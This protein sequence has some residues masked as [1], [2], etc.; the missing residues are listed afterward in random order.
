M[1]ATT[2]Y[3]QAVQGFQQ[4][5]LAPRTNRAVPVASPSILPATNTAL[6][7]ILSSDNSNDEN[8]PRPATATSPLEE[9]FSLRDWTLKAEQQSQQEE[10]ETVDHNRNSNRRIHKGNNNNNNNNSGE[11]KWYEQA[12]YQ[13][14]RQQRRRWLEKTTDSLIQSEPGTLVKGKWHELT[15]MLYAWSSFTKTDA[16]APLRMEAILKRLHQERRAGNREAKADIEMYNRLLDAWACAALF[17]TQPSA[18]VASQRAREILVLLQETYE[19]QQFA[20]EQDDSSII[21]EPSLMPNEESFNLVL[22]VVCR[23]EG[24]TIA[25]RLLAFM[26]YLH[27]SGKNPLAKPKRTDYVSVLTAYT[28]PKFRV[29]NAG[30]LVEGFLRH[31]NI[32]GG[33]APDTFCYNLAIKAWSQSKKGR[34]AAEH[35]DRILEEMQAPKDIV[36]YA[37]VIS[38]WSTSGMRAHAV[39][40]AEEV[41]RQIENEPHLEPNTI[42]L[43]AVMSTWVKSRSPG[44]SNRTGELLKH[45]EESSLPSIQPDLIT[46]NTHLHALSLQAKKPGMAQRADALLQKMENR[47]ARGEVDFAPNLFSYNLVIEAWSKAP[48]AAMKA[49]HVLR[50]LAKAKGVEP[51]TFS[52]NQVLAA[53]SRSSMT[54]Q[55]KMAE[56]LLDYMVKAHREGVH[57][58]AKPDHKGYTHVIQAHARSGV[59]GAA[60]KAERL[61]QHMKDRYF[62]HKEG[63]IKP[64]RHVYN[65]VIHC[66]A[67]SGEGTLGARKAEALLKEMQTLREQ[68]NDESMA[69][70]LVTFNCVLNAWALSGTR[71]CGHKA[72]S[73][74]NQMWEL[75]NAGDNNLVKPN[76]KSYNTV[77]NAISKSKN[78]AKAQRALRILRRMD[79]LYQAGVN[80]EARPNEVTYTAVLNSCAFPAVLDEKT[81]RKALDTAIFTLE[82]LKASRYGHP[83]QITYGTFFKACAN[84]LPDDDNLRRAI[85]QEAFLQC[86]KDGQVGDRVLASFRDASPA[87]LYDELVVSAVQSSP[88]RQSSR[89][90]SVRDLP[91]EWSRNSLRPRSAPNKRR[92]VPQRNRYRP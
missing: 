51:D 85:I 22:H 65:A 57:P 61:L 45:M 13:N 44:A 73:Y 11:E 18:K 16:D 46:Y 31:M 76:D 84:L 24:P 68:Y 39:Q 36:T 8:T 7:S 30:A 47:Y 90:V 50:K 40:R 80:K 38:A 10:Q 28:H 53:L 49:A 20:Q 54:G 72:E 56:E 26:E 9:S 42:V 75:Y 19:Q 5:F 15:S 78:E 60:V 6:F 2:G 48:N 12:E 69:P 87:D 66:W 4:Q 77:I 35:A 43:N 74:L 29:G 41:L 3:P 21:M 63:N 25:R 17:K 1:A 89:R 88:P 33:V 58:Y 79:K 91:K 27:R 83:N 32:T 81:R 23:V 14:K 67:K 82:E 37:S 64:N 86:C 62:L 55:A 34:E 52:F 59:P 92:S 71:C 70:N